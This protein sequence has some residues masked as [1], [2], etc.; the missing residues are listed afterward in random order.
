MVPPELARL[1]RKSLYKDL[2]MFICLAELDRS[3]EEQIIAEGEEDE[4]LVETW[5]YY[6][7]E[8]LYREACPYHEEG[9]GADDM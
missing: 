5:T 4:D 1:R 2:S 7:E 8:F 9:F 3:I 6:Y